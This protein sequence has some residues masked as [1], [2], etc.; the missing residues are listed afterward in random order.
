M[1]KGCYCY[2]GIS[3]GM[4]WHAWVLVANRVPRV[5]QQKVCEREAPELDVAVLRRRS[6]S[7]LSSDLT[8]TSKYGS[9]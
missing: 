2:R 1:Q 9:S 8:E 3:R 6:G 5:R 7:A 4:S